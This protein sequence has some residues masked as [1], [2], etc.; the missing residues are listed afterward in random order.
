MLWLRQIKKVKRELS[1]KIKII[2]TQ[3]EASSWLHLRIDLEKKGTIHQLS[4]SSP[5][6]V[7]RQE[8]YL[9][10]KRRQLQPQL[11]KISSSN[12]SKSH[13]PWLSHQ[14]FR[15]TDSSNY[16]IRTNKS[17]QQILWASECRSIL[18]IKVVQ[19]HWWSLATRTRHSTMIL[20]SRQA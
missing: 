6:K 8:N 12:L 19:V 18:A 13:H 1:L 7:V 15:I 4:G 16:L 20:S 9:F 2:Q 5:I 3:R 11:S 17:S 10:E 14:L